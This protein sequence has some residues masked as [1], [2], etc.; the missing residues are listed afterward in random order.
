MIEPCSILLY[1]HN[2]MDIV[3]K[4]K[5]FAL[6]T[7]F[8]AKFSFN[9]PM[10]SKTTF[11]IGGNALVFVEPEDVSQILDL[12]LWTKKYSVPFFILGGGSNI[13]FTDSTYNGLVISTSKL[14]SISMAEGEDSI[15]Y[16]KCE[17][18]VPIS[19][20]VRFCISNDLW[21][22]QEF[23]G[24]PGTVGGA[25]FM[26]A[27]CFEKSISDLLVSAVCID[28]NKKSVEEYFFNQ[29]DWGYKSSPFCNKNKLVLSAQFRLEKH[30]LD[31]HEQLKELCRDFI[32]QRKQKGHF[33]YPSAG[34]VFK[35]NR[36]FGLPSGKIIDDCGLR[37]MRRGD[38]QVAPFHGNFI[39]NLGAATQKDVKSL[40]ES[41]VNE[42][43]NQ[44]GFELETEI[45]FVDK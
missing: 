14:N 41:V 18:G 8:C 17:C 3:S 36:N 42:V 5:E 37:G 12:L 39:I 7:G 15:A 13:V 21:G 44:T 38:A 32:N 9:E 16:V 20:L 34:S 27:R 4:F 40:V 45:I 10:A 43:R 30:G 25:L 26:N 19:S 1:N 33:D 24:L 11:K 35:N 29:S 22:I 28:L 31:E 23:S 6:K 2:V